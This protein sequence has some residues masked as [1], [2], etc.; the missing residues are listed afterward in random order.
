MIL[1][2]L[3][4]ENNFLKEEL[5]CFP[6][7]PPPTPCGNKQRF[8]RKIPA[9]YFLLNWPSLTPTSAPVLL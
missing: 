8:Q 5:R 3:L 9:V 4:L 7:L 1:T 6:P 2:V